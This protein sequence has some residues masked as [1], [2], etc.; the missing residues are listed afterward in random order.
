MKTYYG[1]RKIKKDNYNKHHEELLNKYDKNNDK[2]ISLDEYLSNELSKGSKEKKGKID[3]SYLDTSNIHNYFYILFLKIKK[4]KIMCIPNSKILIEE[5]F[6]EEKAAVAFVIDK[7][8]LIVSKDIKN[9]INSC[10]KKDKVRFIFFTFL[11]VKTGLKFSHANIIII[12]LIKK[13]VE[14]FEPYG[15]TMP[16]TLA[17]SNILDSIIKKK[18]MKKIGIEKYKYLSPIN[19]SPKSGIQSKEISICGL[20]VTIVMMYL[21]MRILNPD[22]SQRKVV[23]Y[24]T[25]K[26][27]KKLN[28]IVLRYLKNVEETLKSNKNIVINLKKELNI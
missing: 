10:I 8:K 23:E 12:D 26:T 4:F 3:Y 24:F 11:I 7:K 25:S 9:S 1:K 5:G 16:V 20:C 15:H 17:N 14:R 27:K 22:L 6:L 18:L 19:L 28:N 21:H 2:I 13:T